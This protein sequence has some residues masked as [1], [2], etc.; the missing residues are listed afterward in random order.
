[1]MHHAQR[2]EMMIAC[3]DPAHQT[4]GRGRLLPATTRFRVMQEGQ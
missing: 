1:M 4:K 2:D 3:F